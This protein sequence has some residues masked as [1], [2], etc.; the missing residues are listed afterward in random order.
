MKPTM[1]FTGKHTAFDLTAL[2][3]M[4]LD[5]LL[6]QLLNKESFFRRVL[7]ERLKELFH[8]EADEEPKKEA[9]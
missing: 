6:G 7:L 4:V 1:N 2:L 8:E 3:K 5:F 9:K